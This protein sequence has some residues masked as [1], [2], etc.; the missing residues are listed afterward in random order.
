MDRIHQQAGKSYRCA[1]VGRTPRW[2]PWM[3]VINCDGK[4]RVEWPRGLF[5]SIEIF[6]THAAGFK[7]DPS[8]LTSM[9]NDAD[10]ISEN[11]K[12]QQGGEQKFSET[13]HP[14]LN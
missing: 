14:K 1:E 6:F 7:I 11:V 4:I 12:T 13:F 8:H 10:S 3:F 9:M 5:I 2:P